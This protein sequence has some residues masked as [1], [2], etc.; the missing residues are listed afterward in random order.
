MTYLFLDDVH[1]SLFKDGENVV[2][3]T[4]TGCL[5]SLI[6]IAITEPDKTFCC[7]E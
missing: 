2:E 3:I 7:N 5:V 1:S 4:R 6:N